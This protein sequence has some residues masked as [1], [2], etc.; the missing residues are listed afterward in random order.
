MAR[1]WKFYFSSL[2]YGD[3]KASQPAEAGSWLSLTIR[4]NRLHSPQHT[5]AVSCL[6]SKDHVSLVYYRQHQSED[7]WYVLYWACNNKPSL[8]FSP[9][10]LHSQLAWGLWVYRV[11]VH[12]HTVVRVKYYFIVGNT[13]IQSQIILDYVMSQ[14][15]AIQ[16]QII[17]P[18][19]QK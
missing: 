17:L 6:F 4:F 3:Y 16:S 7:S 19:C 18:Y 2:D 8:L 10:H 11:C 1:A 12:Q 15:T 13:A 14:N 9:R 5:L